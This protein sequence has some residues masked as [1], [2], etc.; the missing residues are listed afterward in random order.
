MST[1]S[2]FK[3]EEI[4]PALCGIATSY[5][6]ESI[7]DD[8]DNLVQPILNAEESYIYMCFMITLWGSKK[9]G[10]FS[11]KRMYNAFLEFLL[12]VWREGCSSEGKYKLLLKDVFDVYWLMFRDDG[13]WKTKSDYIP[14]DKALELWR[15][16]SSSEIMI[17][18]K[19]EIKRCQKKG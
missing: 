18:C 10:G 1:F 5:N 7:I 14:Y 9:A 4:T 19:E 3:I 6:L 8:W 11:K 16:K 12:D 17:I 2:D 15:S 13:Y